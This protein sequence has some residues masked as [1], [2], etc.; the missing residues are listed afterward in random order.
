M[1]RSRYIVLVEDK[2]TVYYMT[3]YM[4]A[5]GEYDGMIHEAT[6][7]RA[8]ASIP[9]LTLFFLACLLTFFLQ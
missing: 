1:N 9:V 4:G 3:L 5:T 2:G 8:V 6:A 7:M